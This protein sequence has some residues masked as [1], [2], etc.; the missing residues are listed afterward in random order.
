LLSS[1]KSSTEIVFLM[2]GKYIEY[3]T[4]KLSDY[5]VVYR[6]TVLHTLHFITRVKDLYQLLYTIP[7]TLKAASFMGGPQPR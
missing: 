2:L 1:Q 7:F 5:E 3:M 4:N 6:I